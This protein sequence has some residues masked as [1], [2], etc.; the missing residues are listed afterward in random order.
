METTDRKIS[1]SMLKM[2]IFFF[3]QNQNA[4]GINEEAPGELEIYYR[5]Q[6]SNFAKDVQ[7]ISRYILVLH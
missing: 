1:V 6:I 7:Y 2:H 3:L 4:G 5:R